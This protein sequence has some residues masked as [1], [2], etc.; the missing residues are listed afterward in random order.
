MSSLRQ[1]FSPTPPEA[2]LLII[3]AALLL[4]ATT[5]SD[6]FEELPITTVFGNDSYGLCYGYYYC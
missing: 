1:L 4:L 5:A 6:Y 2:L 3:M